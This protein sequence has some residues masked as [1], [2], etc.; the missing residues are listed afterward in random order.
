MIHTKE[1]KKVLFVYPDMGIGGSTTSL[2]SL[3]NTFDYHKYDIDLALY[4]TGYIQERYLSEKI[5][6]LPACRKYQHTVADKCIKAFFY[7]VTIIKLLFSRRHINKKSI[8]TEF[9]VLY[10]SK[11]IASKYDVAIGYLEGWAD[12][13]VAR[14]IKQCKKIMWIHTDIVNN[15][16]VDHSDMRLYLKKADTIVC[17][18]EKLLEGISSTFPEFE[19]KTIFL[20]NI[21]SKKYVNERARELIDESEIDIINAYSG[22]KI[23]SVCRFSVFI[24]GIDRMVGIAKKL[25]EDGVNF[26]WY[27]IGDGKE[28]KQVAE[29]VKKNDIQDHFFL[30]GEKNNPYPFMYKCD[31]LALPSRAEGKPMVVTEAQMLG[32]IPVVTRYASSEEQIRHGVDGLISDNNEESYYHMLYSIIR[33]KDTIKKMK[34]QIL[35][36]DYSNTI[37]IQKYYSVL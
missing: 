10:N 30:L 9:T 6:V 24:K 37:D 5:K 1:K 28:K 8:Y 26:R 20:P 4:D 18:S 7:I 34:N 31:I 17:V 3:L 15:H 12:S 33:D 13:Y 23:I 27:L 11:R 35:Q 16:E 32:I 19:K 2:V 22:I 25:K 36:K 29:M 14:N 21:L